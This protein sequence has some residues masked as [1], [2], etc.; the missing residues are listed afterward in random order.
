MIV[1]TGVNMPATTAG[2]I[3][4]NQGGADKPAQYLF[5]PSPTYPT[6]TVVIARSPSN[7]VAGPATVRS[8][9]GP[10]ST[11]AWPITIVATAT[12]PVL[13]GLRAS[14]A[15]TTDLTT[16]VPGQTGLRAGG[17]RRY[18]RHDLPLAEFRQLGDLADD[19]GVHDR[20]PGLDL[21]RRHR[22]DRGRGVHQW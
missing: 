4:F 6:T 2:G 17:R 11:R 13:R 7:L 9:S 12:P 8:V 21:H 14:C 1:L 20:R 22:A 19:P 3:V 10:L 5:Y 16:I 15:S 18:G